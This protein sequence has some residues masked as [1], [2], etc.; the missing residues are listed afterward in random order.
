M[1]QA[2]ATQA[3]ANRLSVRPRSVAESPHTRFVYLEDESRGATLSAPGRVVI[4]IHGF[5]TAPDAAERAFR[6]FTNRLVAWI[7][8]DDIWEF[9]W[10]GDHPNIWKSKATYSSRATEAPSIGERL[11]EF[12][13]RR[14]H[15]K[16][17]ILVAHSLGCRIA[18][19]ATL[20][21]HAEIP[22]EDRPPIIHTFLLAA[23]VP[24]PMCEP[25]TGKF[26]APL[27]G[28]REHAFFSPDDKV[29]SLF[30]E[31]GQGFVGPLEVGQAVGLRGRPGPERWHEPWNTWL[32]HN[33][34][35]TDGRVSDEVLRRLGYAVAQPVARRRMDPK[36]IVSRTLVRAVLAP[37]KLRSRRI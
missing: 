26:T 9:H 15:N 18:L 25:L 22:S 30:F 4:L 33:E 31:P 5:N 27:A 8:A 28:S 12:I 3:D 17:V 14:L 21:V 35:W 6:A 7:R 23:A 29:L 19:E 10:P 36:R 32:D 16:Q 37:R 13:T 20:Q 24:S 1:K 11:G 2:G 34:Y